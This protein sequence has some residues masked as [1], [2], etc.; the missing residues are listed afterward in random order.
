MLRWSHLNTSAVSS[1]T[2]CS[3]VLVPLA[4]WMLELFLLSLLLVSGPGDVCLLRWADPS[5]VFWQCAALRAG[6][7]SPAP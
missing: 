7:L 2:T 5:P 1:V 3:Q 4:L 6:L